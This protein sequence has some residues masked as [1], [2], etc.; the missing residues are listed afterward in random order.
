MTETGALVSERYGKLNDFQR[1]AADAIAQGWNSVDGSFVLPMVEG[2]PGTGKTTVG[3]VGISKLL[4]EEPMTQ[5]GYLAYTNFA[6]E[7]AREEFQSLGYQSDTVLRL[8]PNPRETNWEKG[9]VGSYRPD[10]SDLTPNDLRRVR[11]ARILVSTLQSSG[12]VFSVHKNPFIVIDEFSQVPPNLFFSTLSKV[13]S[14]TRFNPA[15]YVLLGDPNQLPVITSQPLLRP[16]IGTFLLSRKRNYSPYKLETQYRMHGKICAAVNALREVLNCYPLQTHGTVIDRTLEHIGYRYE[17]GSVAPVLGD[18]LDPGNPLVI[19]DTDGLPGAEQTGFGMSTYY[20]EEAKLTTKLANKLHESFKKSD[21]S[22]LVPRILS[23]YNAQIS[24][25]QSESRAPAVS[26]GCMTIYKSQGR[27]YPVVMIS[28]AR[29]NPRRTIGFL[30]EPELRA[31]TYVGC[32][33]AMAKLI[34]LFSFSTFQGYPD[35]AALLEKC[36]GTAVVVDAEELWKA[37]G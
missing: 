36:K 28:F 22:Q 13:S 1:H 30:A 2:P 37:I 23:P 14:T 26:D 20:S 17:P 16:N 11:R 35:F 6:A 4:Q 29:K 21:G 27:E 10:L 19:I 25:I 32:S 3:V 9:V 8:T 5:I 33:R 34:L 18:V 15:S 24:A 7:K 31:Q 12:R